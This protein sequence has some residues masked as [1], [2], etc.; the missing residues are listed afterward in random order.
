MTNLIILQ[1]ASS[2]VSELEKKDFDYEGDVHLFIRKIDE[3]LT[4]LLELTKTYV[5]EIPEVIRNLMIMKQDLIKRSRQRKS[6]T[7]P[8]TIVSLAAPKTEDDQLALGRPKYLF[9]EETLI[10]YRELGFT[11]TEISDMLLVSRWTIRRRIKEYGLENVLG[12]SKISDEELDK[13]F[14]EYK[15]KHGVCMW[16]INGTW[17]S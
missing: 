17:L 7:V 13:L 15:Q 6:N 4:G 8:V 11:W 5:E 14:F 1:E 2:L 16:K 3:T 10:N 9:S 12:N